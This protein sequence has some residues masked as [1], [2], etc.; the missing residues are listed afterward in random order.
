M[1]VGAVALTG[2]H[3]ASV[4]AAGFDA[5]EDPAGFGGWDWT[6]GSVSYVLRGFD[7]CG[8]GTSSILKT[9]GPPGSWIT[10]AFICAFVGY[11][12]LYL[13]FERAYGRHRCWL[14]VRYQESVVQLP[15]SR[16]DVLLYQPPLADRGHVSLLRLT[17]I[18]PTQLSSHLNNLWR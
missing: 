18:L 6:L 16:M 8:Q 7:V 14:I 10:A 17:N 2:E 13:V 5:D 3:F 1:D 4:Q 12:R 9:S 11:W 15:A